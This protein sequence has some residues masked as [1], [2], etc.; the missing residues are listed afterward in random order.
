MA[1]ARKSSKHRLAHWYACA[2]EPVVATGHRLA[3]LPGRISIGCSRGRCVAKSAQVLRGAA[4][5]AMVWAAADN[6][7]S[8]H[9]IFVLWFWKP[10]LPY[11]SLALLMS[12]WAVLCL[13]G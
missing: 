10:E 12:E 11:P 13:Q 5:A 6:V 7:G 2:E 9:L 8:L 3:G 4:V 1:P